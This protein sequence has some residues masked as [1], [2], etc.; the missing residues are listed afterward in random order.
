MAE[1]TGTEAARAAVLMRKARDME[2]KE[3]AVLRRLH[4]VKA[5]VSL[6]KYT[7]LRGDSL[8]SSAA[9]ADLETLQEQYRH[10]QPEA[11]EQEL[12]DL[13]INGSFLSSLLGGDGSAQRSPTASVAS[14]SATWS[15]SS[16]PS[17][18]PVDSRKSAV[19]AIPV[20]GAA[21]VTGSSTV[22]SP[23]S[24]PSALTGKLEHINGGDD[25]CTGDGGG[26]GHCGGGGERS[27]RTQPR[28]TKQQ[29]QQQPRQEGEHKHQEEE[30]QP[31]EQG[32]QNQQQHQPKWSP[33]RLTEEDVRVARAQLERKAERV[34]VVKETQGVMQ[35]IIR[36]SLAL[37]E[38]AIAITDTHQAIRRQSLQDVKET[39]EAGEKTDKGAKQVLAKIRAWEKTARTS[40]ALAFEVAGDVACR[41]QTLRDAADRLTSGMETQNAQMQLLAV[42]RVLNGPV[43]SLAPDSVD[44]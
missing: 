24:R 12:A 28:Q 30:Q 18:P 16:S 41:A 43:A 9:Y 22:S 33:K 5:D 4:K 27:Q 7:D 37:S 35:E 19:L 32:G 44:R 36:R 11:H 17:L 25:R 20:V 3:L 29:P 39:R 14:P 23:T 26:H 38:R 6:D 42:F 8:R 40:E 13:A 2:A 21:A 15:P 34:R 10:R 31:T 1:F